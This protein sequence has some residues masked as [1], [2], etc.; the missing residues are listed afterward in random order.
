MREKRVENR[1]TDSH[2][3]YE[4]PP[5]QAL[6]GR[7]ISW[8]DVARRGVLYDGTFFKM[9]RAV[10]ATGLGE[11]HG[12]MRTPHLHS[13]IEAN[14]VI[15]GAIEY[16]FM[17]HME[18][19]EAGQIALFWAGFPHRLVACDEKTQMFW[20]NMPVAWVLQWKG[21]GAL[22]TRLLGGELARECVR[23]RRELEEVRF[24]RWMELLQSKKPQA[25]LI[26][27]LEVEAMVRWFDLTTETDSSGSESRPYKQSVN[28]VLQMAK[29]MSTHF[30]DKLSIQK[31][32]RA[33]S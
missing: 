29:F 15:E 1:R 2:T 5:V 32:A 8:E 11:P 16:S 9:E 27:A 21:I 28:H 3:L 12:P 22:L 7:E 30:D 19:V 18:R 20:I 25:D 14:F 6:S 17:G 24:Q 13:D 33:A 23:S 4:G 26:V 31:I 10:L